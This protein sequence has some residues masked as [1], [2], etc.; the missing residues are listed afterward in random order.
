VRAGTANARAGSGLGAGILRLR[1]ASVMAGLSAL[2]DARGHLFPFV[3]VLVGIGI[4]VWFAL[5]FEPGAA[6]YAGVGAV[7]LA[8]L[9]GRLV[10]PDAGHVP[11]LAVLWLA[12][13]VLAAGGRAH[14][15]AAPVLE[16]RLYGPVE[17]R[18]IEVDRS[19]ADHLRLTLDRLRVADLPAARTPHSVRVSIHA[20]QPHI[21]LVP[22]LRVML[23][24][25]LSPPQPP[26]EPG[27]FDFR[28]IA[29]FERLGGVG[30][31]RTP[32]LEVEEPDPRA[33]L[34]DRLRTHLSRV[35]QDR[36]PGQAG[37]FAAGAVT[38]DR[39]GITQDTVAALRDSNLAHLLAISGMNLAFLVG[40]VFALVRTGIALVPPVALRV[41]GKKI[42]AL[43]AL[44]VAAFYLA[45][46][47]GNVATE[48]AFLMVAVMLVAVLADRQAV[49]LRTV[50]IAA[51]IIL[52]WK[53]EELLN[54]GFQMSMAAT[55]ALVAGFAALRDRVNRDRVPRWM[56]PVYAAVLSTVIA[57]LATAP[58]AAAHFNR[59]TD[60]GMLAN[61][62]TVPAMGTF[63]MPG[64]AIAALLGPIGL[65]A[66]GFWLM[67]IG[68]RWILTVA[69][70]I[71]GWEGSVTGI[72]A[73]GT[74]VLP[75]L[76]LGVLWAIL[77]RGPARFA[78]AVPVVVAMVLWAMTERPPVLV[79]A[80]G[81]LSGVLDGGPRALSH[82]RGAG[83]S[84]ELWLERDGDLAAQDQAAARR[85]FADG[86]G[87]RL[88]QVGGLTVLHLKGRSGP[89]RLPDACDRPTV[90]ILSEDVAPP[91]PPGCTV[92]DAARLAA[93]G[94]AAIWPEGGT[95]RIVP[96][97]GPE[98]LW[99]PAP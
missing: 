19:R 64:A 93:L 13:G 45:L 3:P 21:D 55:V 78:G 61:L 76:T 9:A 95:L 67:E 77:W 24:A 27:A 75:I 91:D 89:E 22:G 10:L 43:V 35:V 74:A 86:Q 96:A 99:A 30:Y 87:G 31:S 12:L 7:A 88:A 49:S 41:N 18:I 16:W 4:G 44:P 97:R 37:A 81:A 59:F 92:L 1:G 62:L 15:V 80:D 52:L 34:I 57:G 6:V 69:H 90:V 36:I 79:S 26:A 66:P 48:R 5:P 51:L 40:F 71:A 54:A 28:R 72:P 47:G 58:L 85:G 65:G 53:P 83:F 8:A 60:Y 46:S 84:A 32:V 38:G 11:A 94:G 98:R 2:Q 14:L 68:S 39:S 73:P 25:N 33:Q 42:A 70:W 50:A 29:W 17:G 23:T 56:L 20:D 63:V 82:D